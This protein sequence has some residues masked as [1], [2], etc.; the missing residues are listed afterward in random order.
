MLP[1]FL[2]PPPHSGRV[3]IGLLILRVVLGLAFIQYGLTKIGHPMSWANPYG[4]SLPAFI[5]PLTPLAELGG[6]I[7]LL[8]GLLTPV[9]AIGIA[10]D[11]IFAVILFVAPHGGMIWISPKPTLTFEKNIFYEAG[12][13]ALL[14]CGPGL[15]SI[16]AMLARNARDAALLPSRR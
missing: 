5:Q 14:F 3:S 10:I 13:L 9:A 6:G 7:L 1:T 4:I 11:M 12:A 2:Q 15:Y 16:D 8:F